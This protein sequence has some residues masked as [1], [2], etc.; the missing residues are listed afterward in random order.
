MRFWV[1]K[2]GKMGFGGYE[3]IGKKVGEYRIVN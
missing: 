2:L 3:E 1:E